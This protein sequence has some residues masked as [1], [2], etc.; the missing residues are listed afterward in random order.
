MSFG[1]MPSHQHM[2]MLNR[3]DYLGPKSLLEGAGLRI[4]ML[5]YRIRPLLSNQYHKS[6]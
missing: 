5:L 6:V 4:E 1:S 3:E 2:V